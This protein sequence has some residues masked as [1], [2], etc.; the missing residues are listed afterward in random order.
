MLNTL[1]DGEQEGSQKRVGDECYG[2]EQVHKHPETGAL[3]VQEEIQLDP[4]AT[5]SKI[6][7]LR[8]EML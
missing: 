8:D 1:A 5:E 3:K 4:V 6:I 2:F 7:R